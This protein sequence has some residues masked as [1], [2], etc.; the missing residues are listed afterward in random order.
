MFSYL[1]AAQAGYGFMHPDPR[2]E[3]FKFYLITAPS[4][5]PASVTTK[6]S[7]NIKRGRQMSGDCGSG[8]SCSKITPNRLRRPHP[9]GACNPGKRSYPSDATA[10]EGRECAHMPK[11]RGLAGVLGIYPRPGR[12]WSLRRT[13]LPTLASG[14]NPG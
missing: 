4:A 12:Q 3:F 6:I 9:R 11:A 2:K 1:S 8:H 7:S 14:K 10:L 13:K 5:L